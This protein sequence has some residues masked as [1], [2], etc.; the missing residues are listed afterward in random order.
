MTTPGRGAVGGATF[1][2]ASSTEVGNVRALNEDAVL[3]APPVFFVADGMGGHEA[4]E[5]ASALAVERLRTLGDGV[6]SS[7]DAVSSELHHINELLRSAA[8]SDQQHSMGT[9]GVGLAVVDNGGL[10]SWLIFN[11][12][13][14]RAYCWTGRELV[15]LSRDHSFVQDLVDAGEI[16]A[17]D[18]RVHPHRNVVTRAFGADDELQPD[19]WIRPVRAGERFLLC[20]DGLTGEVEDEVLATVLA[21][22]LGPAETVDILVGLALEAGGRDNVTTLIVDV[23]D[24]PALADETTESRGRTLR[25]FDPTPA[26]GDDDGDT[27]EV[28]VAPGAG[29]REAGSAAPLIADV[30]VRTVAIAGPGPAA[31]E[32]SPAAIASVPRSTAPEPAGQEAAPPETGSLIEAMP[33]HLARSAADADPPPTAPPSDEVATIQPLRREGGDG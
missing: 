33:S 19:Y 18:A 20:S 15:Q 5:I 8:G 32:G 29:E 2:W 3:V 4:G 13:D 16:D 22:G 17:A 7:I 23:V 12:G 28:V 30:P 11:V 10:V 24:G 31:T 26:V 9:T 25:G 14:S 27:R 6:P 21:S 1:A